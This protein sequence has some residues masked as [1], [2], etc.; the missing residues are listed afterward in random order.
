MN[1]NNTH[2]HTYIHT[3]RHLKCHLTLIQPK[4]LTDN[5][6]QFLKLSMIYILRQMEKYERY[7]IKVEYHVIYNVQGFVQNC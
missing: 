1:K 5:M 2:A 4:N 6:T 7:Y 3:Y